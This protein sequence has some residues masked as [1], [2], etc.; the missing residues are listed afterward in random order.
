MAEEQSIQE[1]SDP[2]TQRSAYKQ[3]WS[4]VLQTCKKSLLSDDDRLSKISEYLDDESNKELCYQVSGGKR[5]PLECNCLSCLKG[6]DYDS[7]MAVAQYFLWFAEL[8]KQT[9]QLLVMEKIRAADSAQRNKRS[10]FLPFKDPGNVI[11]GQEMGQTMI[12]LRAFFTVLRIG[13]DWYY[14]T[15]RSHVN[16]GTIPVHKSTGCPSPMSKLFKE[17]IELHLQS[18]FED[19]LKTMAGPRESAP[20]TTI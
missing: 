17:E 14:A 9:Q 20:E 15:C 13:K 1:G 3:N 16:S 18:F 11:T 6:E 5:G 10:F 7:K 8:P 4:T 19:Y 2:Q 12:C